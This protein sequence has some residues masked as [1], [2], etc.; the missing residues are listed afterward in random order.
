MNSFWMSQMKKEFLKT[1][2]ATA[3]VCF[4]SFLPPFNKI[5]AAQNEMVSIQVASEA[6]IDIL[7]RLNIDII[8]IHKPKFLRSAFPITAALSCKG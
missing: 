3:F 1:S 6:D 5:E 7:K 4:C 2:V 8:N